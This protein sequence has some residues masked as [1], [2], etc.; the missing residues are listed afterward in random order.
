MKLVVF[1]LS[2]LFV[3]SCNDQRTE[4]TSSNEKLTNIQRVHKAEFQQI[5]DSLMLDGSILIYDTSTLT[6]YS[7]DFEWSEQGHIPASTYKIPHT[8]IGL[9]LGI[10]SDTFVFRYDGTPRNMSIWEQDLKLKDALQFSCVPC[11][12]S[13]ARMIGVDSMK[14]YLDKLNYGSMIF[15]EESLD[16]FWLQGASRINQFQQIEFLQELYNG[17]LDVSIRNQK[18]VREMLVIQEDSIGTLSGKTGWSIDG[19]QNSGWFVGYLETD[20]SMYFFASNIE[21]MEDFDIR[22]FPAVRRIAVDLAFKALT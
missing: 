9:E 20:Q 7:N 12:Q 2:L 8:L 1:C 6:F 14:Y 10:L 21:P 18:L 17:E 19:D 15:D 16:M 3:F 11:Y 22:E 13:L 4:S 5:L